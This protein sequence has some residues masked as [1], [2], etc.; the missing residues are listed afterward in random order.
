MQS[1]SENQ[2]KHITHQLAS[3]NNRHCIF[4][5]YDFQTKHF[6]LILVRKFAYPPPLL[7]L[8]VALICTD[9]VLVVLFVLSFPNWDILLGLI[10]YLSVR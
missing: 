7:E 2:D 9:D 4:V 5:S 3:L 1:V 10:G 6:I 8:I